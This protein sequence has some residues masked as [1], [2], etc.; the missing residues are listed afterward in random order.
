MAAANENSLRVEP[1]ARRAELAAFSR[2]LAPL[3][4][5]CKTGIVTRQGADDER[6]AQRYA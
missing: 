3:E 5:G 6:R 2:A 4:G 1:A